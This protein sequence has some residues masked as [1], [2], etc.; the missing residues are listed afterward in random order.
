MDEYKRLQEK[1]KVEHQ[2]FLSVVENEIANLVGDFP[3]LSLECSER[4]ITVLIHRSSCLTF[5]IKDDCFLVGNLYDSDH[6]LFKISSLDSF[7]EFVIQLI[8]NDFIPEIYKLFK[9]TTYDHDGHKIPFIKN[10][11]SKLVKTDKNDLS[12]I[13]KDWLIEE[14]YNISSEEMN[15]ETIENIKISGNKKEIKITLDLN[16]GRYGLYR[17][18]VVTV[19][20]RG[21]VHINFGE[22][23]IEGSGVERRLEKSIQNKIKF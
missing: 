15:G 8:E 21:G 12:K 23:P 17:N 3:E 18:Q 5:Y 7:R 16:C 10:L 9:L 20:D 19:N 14:F 1:Y 6:K 13:T 4:G 11:P 2:R 22:N